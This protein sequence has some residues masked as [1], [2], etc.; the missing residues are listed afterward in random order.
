MDRLAEAGGHTRLDH[1][2]D[3][4]APHRLGGPGNLEALALENIFQPVK[5]KVIGEL[6]GCDESQ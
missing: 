1:I 4:S 3:I 2:R 5:W 6:A